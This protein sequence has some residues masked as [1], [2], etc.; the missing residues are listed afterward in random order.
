[1]KIGIF[2]GLMFGGLVAMALLGFGAGMVLIAL[3]AAFG[4]CELL[5]EKQAARAAESWRANYP[6]YGY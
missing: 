1:M 4:G 2:G 3:G 6:P 5:R